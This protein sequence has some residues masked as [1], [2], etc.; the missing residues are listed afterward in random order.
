MCRCVITS[1]ALGFQGTTLST[2]DPLTLDSKVRFHSPT[3]CLDPLVLDQT[4]N[5]LA[6]WA[7][8]HRTQRPGLWSDASQS[9]I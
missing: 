7:V 6:L 5:P 8:Q 1:S 2:G 9:S 4:N 3:W